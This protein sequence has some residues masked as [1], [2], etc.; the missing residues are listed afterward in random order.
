M[1]FAAASCLRQTRLS[2]E[3]EREADE[4]GGWKSGGP[5]SKAQ[6]ADP[7]SGHESR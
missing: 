2:E 7:L 4:F 6:R 3:G 1:Q 5:R